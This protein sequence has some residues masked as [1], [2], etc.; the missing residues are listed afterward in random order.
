MSFLFSL[1]VIDSLKRI[2]Q[3]QNRIENIFFLSRL[4]LK[5]I[6]LIL[7][8]NPI[9]LSGRILLYILQ[10]IHIY[11]PVLVEIVVM[12]IIRTAVRGYFGLFFLFLVFVL[13]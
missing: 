11:F 9:Y 12:F 1:F 8:I 5:I 13:F 10:L 3:K 7:L 2:R 6:F 4:Q